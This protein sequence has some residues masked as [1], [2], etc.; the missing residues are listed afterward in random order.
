[1]SV[2]RPPLPRRYELK[3]LLGQ[4]GM[5]DVWLGRVR[6]LRRSVAVKVAQ[7]RWVGHA[8]LLRRFT[9]EAQLTSQLQHPGIPPVYETGQLPDGRPY[10]CM[11][12]VRGRTLATLLARRGQ[13]S[14]DLPKLLAIFE[15]VCQAVAYAH[16]KSVI[17]RDLKPHN[18]MVG[19]FGEVQVMDWG[20]AKV[21]KEGATTTETV[22]PS[23]AASVVETDRAEQGEY[24]T[25]AGSMLGTLAYMPPEQ[26]LGEVERLDERADV[27]G[28][29]SILCEILTGSPPYVGSNTAQVQRKAIRADLADALT[30]LD[31][32]GADPELVSLTKRCLAVEPDD[33]PRDAGVLA[34][35]L[36][37]HLESVETRLRQAELEGAE[38]R[39]RATEERKR[40]RLVL[41]LASAVL[42]LVLLG[43]GG[44]LYVAHQ[45][46]ERRREVH[47]RQAETVR[48]V[49]EVLA[50]VDTLR[51]RA[52][53][54]NDPDAWAEARALAERAK[55]LLADL[56]D[57]HELT[58]RV[59]ALADELAAEEQDRKLLERLEEVWLLRADFDAHSTGFALR[60]SLREY[61]PLF[62]EHGLHV[63]AG[64]AESAAW[65]LR[66]PPL[67][68][69]RLIAGLD[70]W[71]GLARQLKAPEAAWL[72]GVLQAADGDGWRKSLRAA[73]DRDD[74]PEVDRLAQSEA[75]GRQ[76]PQTVLLLADY[77]R[78][79]SQA[80]LTQLL[81][82]A[83]A[84]YPADF[85]INFALADALYQ[86]HLTALSEA[87]EFEDV[88]RF[89]TTAL[90]L[91][92]ENLQVQSLL[93]WAL[94]L[95]GR[96]ADGRLVLEQARARQPNYFAPHL[97]LGHMSMLEGK[98]QEAEASY[99]EALKLQPR[100]GLAHSGMGFLLFSR[101]QYAEALLAFRRGTRH[102]PFSRGLLGHAGVLS[103]LVRIDE[104]IAVCRQALRFQ[105]D[106]TEAQLYQ[107]LFTLVEN[108]RSAEADTLARGLVL[109]QPNNPESHV[110]LW[111]CLLAQ[112][113]LV[114]MRPVIRRALELS[115]KSPIFPIDMLSLFERETEQ[116]IALEPHLPAYIKGERK[117]QDA[118]ELA[119]LLVLC[120]VKE[121][122][123]GAAQLYVHALAADPRLT[124]D[125]TH[126]HR[127]VA[128]RY[129]AQAA[130]GQGDGS[131]L[132][133]AARARWR[134]Q[135]LDWL[136]AD[137]M[138]WRKLLE[139][140]SAD[141]QDLARERLRWWQTDPKLAGL[142][143]PQTLTKLPPKEHDACQL[144]WAEL[145][146]LVGEG[147]Q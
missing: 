72:F 15:Q 4:G 83:Q 40:R 23:V 11:K 135:A 25:Q 147:P 95:R 71:L 97:Y 116:F 16:S 13:T 5:G 106:F 46:E 21:L 124:E 29:G 88:V 20:L 27:F 89:Y 12:V 84:H 129:A 105:P 94:W 102:E 51:Q 24:L 1:M 91:R 101:G 81:R 63:A 33:R 57:G 30:R 87:T 67:I 66:H 132:D 60:R 110:F 92:P 70:A 53:A 73:V 103:H 56:P 62:A 137:L 6:R 76:P 58:G 42:G 14:D 19:A 130:V 59:Q 3:R 49:Q 78:P 133:E 38:A 134:A 142:R 2:P 93:G 82:A 8:N 104:G 17:H 36:T 69:E 35:E 117:P 138:G 125:V 85:W 146:A 100:S 68:R 112:G 139:K 28:L 90:A 31:G 122:Y 74:V 37:A 144:L 43:G 119:M 9:Q 113:R 75:L 7:Q 118:Q 114:E 115:P 54:A 121:Q 123:A 136:R 141:E 41:A 32:C 61:A 126:E 140:G 52:Q 131:M 108:R 128:A 120:W 143:D 98:R 55:S 47:E 107:R 80:R 22:A 86:K 34:R 99:G 39:A 96:R 79:R 145:A 64:E 50:R 65:V 77:F 109:L 127:Y 18:V 26:A 45:R 10:F 48:R 44:W 111:H